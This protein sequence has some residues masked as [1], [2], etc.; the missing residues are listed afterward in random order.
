MPPKGYNGYS[1]RV[2]VAERLDRLIGDW[3]VDVSEAIR[4]LLDNY[5]RCRAPEAS[6]QPRE[7]EPS[8]SPT[9]TTNP[10]IE[11]RREGRFN[12][13]EFMERVKAMGGAEYREKPRRLNP[14]DYFIVMSSDDVPAEKAREALGV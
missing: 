14:R 12:T 10:N 1:V 6:P 9:T 8:P 7:Q 13:E 3:G 5:D 2:E 4:R 11:S